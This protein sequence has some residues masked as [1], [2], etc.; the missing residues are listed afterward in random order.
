MSQ[1]WKALLTVLCLLFAG[2]MLIV[3]YFPL[4]Q[5]VPSFITQGAV[6]ARTFEA[7]HEKVLD[8][9]LQSP[10]HAV[11]R[12][13]V[14]ERYLIDIR[15]DDGEV[16]RGTWP[17]PTVDQLPLGQRVSVTCE[18]RGFAPIWHKTYVKEI[19]VIPTNRVQ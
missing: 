10:S 12:V 8:S 15:L 3:L 5:S 16:V 19:T 1:S 11:H 2:V 13:A 18:R 14:G 4:T 17:V 9:P 6:I 7:A